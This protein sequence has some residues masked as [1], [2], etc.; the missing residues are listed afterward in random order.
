MP[1]SVKISRENKL[2][3]KNPVLMNNGLHNQTQQ[4]PSHTIQTLAMPLANLQGPAIP[5]IAQPP[6]GTKPDGG[7]F[8]SFLNK[9]VAAAAEA[10]KKEIAEKV[11][12]ATQP[13]TP[14]STPNEAQSSTL[15]LFRNKF[16]LNTETDQAFQLFLRDQIQGPVTN[17]K[18]YRFT[19]GQQS[20]QAPSVASTESL[21]AGPTLQVQNSNRN[22]NKTPCRTV[23]PHS[24]FSPAHIAAKTGPPLM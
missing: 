12:V 1:V 2:P 6:S 8:L 17:G 20:P 11:G 14:W 18:K 16:R 23:D 4:F 15:P 3:A 21:N 7:D 5:P 22:A 10:K 19:G 13:A 9:K 24:A